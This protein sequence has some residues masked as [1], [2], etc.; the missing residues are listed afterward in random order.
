MDTWRG[1]ALFFVDIWRLGGWLRWAFLA[2]I[3][4]ILGGWPYL[5]VR[6]LKMVV[7]L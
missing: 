5:I 2:V 3:L 1:V 4:L 7:Q 6:F